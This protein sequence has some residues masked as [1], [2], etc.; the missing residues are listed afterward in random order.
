MSIFS[1]VLVP[2]EKYRITSTVVSPG[3]IKLERRLVEY[4]TLEVPC[5]PILSFF[6]LLRFDK[7]DF[8]P[9]KETTFDSP[10]TEALWKAVINE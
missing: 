8:S 9:R 6:G 10:E 7:G 4:T 1:R 3:H 2:S 5:N